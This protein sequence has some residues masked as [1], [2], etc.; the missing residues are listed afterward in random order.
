MYH[1]SGSTRSE[2][3][4]TLRSVGVSRLAMISGQAEPPG[5]ARNCAFSDTAGCADLTS[6]R[7]TVV[8]LV[9][10]SLSESESLSAASSPSAPALM[11][12]DEDVTAL[13]AVGCFLTGTTIGLVL[14]P[15][16]AAAAR[17]NFRERGNSLAFVV[18]KRNSFRLKK[19]KTK[20]KKK[21]IRLSG[22]GLKNTCANLVAVVD[23]RLNKDL[24]DLAVL[25]LLL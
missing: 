7:G 4:R 11:G 16:L 10:A 5:S 13:D 6:A 23:Q 8:L 18:W 20:T 22:N 9:S 3:R 17:G 15:L 24:G 19:T 25:L 12:G 21:H 1:S 14:A 2:I